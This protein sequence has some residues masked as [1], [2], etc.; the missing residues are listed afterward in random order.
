MRPVRRSLISA[1]GRTT[2]TCPLPLLRARRSR[3]LPRLTP[4]L[5]QQPA[6]LNQRIWLPIPNRQ[7][8]RCIRCLP[9]LVNLANPH[10]NN[11][12]RLYFQV[13]SWLLLRQRGEMCRLL[14]QRSLLLPH[15][16]LKRLLW[17]M[18]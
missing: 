13:A 15:G 16:S 5:L 12:P 1:A 4:F 3:V 9:N 18:A 11:L 10:S 17:N 2:R 7:K 14:R 6:R 8:R